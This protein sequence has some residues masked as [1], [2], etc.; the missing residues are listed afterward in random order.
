[1]SAAGRRS[2]SGPIFRLEGGAACTS[3][4]GGARTR[5]GARTLDGRA[6]LWAGE[7]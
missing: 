6:G 1:M 3:R 2:E 7:G 4:R 5:L